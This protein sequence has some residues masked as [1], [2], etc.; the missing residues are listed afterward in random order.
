MGSVHCISR[1]EDTL[2]A[3]FAEPAWTRVWMSALQASRQK[4]PLEQWE[5]GTIQEKPKYPPDS[6]SAALGSVWATGKHLNLS[7]GMEENSCWAWQNIFFVDFKWNILLPVSDF[8]IKRF[9]FFPYFFLSVCK[10]HANFYTNLKRMSVSHHF[11]FGKQTIQ[12]QLPSPSCNRQEKNTKYSSVMAGILTAKAQETV[13][14]M[15]CYAPLWG[16]VHIATYGYSCS[17]G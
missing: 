15:W 7:W 16:Y 14:Y 9:Y 12:N 11:K 5:P 4:P 3:D 13:I 6:S 10:A 8:I 2:Q 17:I 1:E